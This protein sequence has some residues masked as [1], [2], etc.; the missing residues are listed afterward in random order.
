VRGSGIGID[1]KR[2][3]LFVLPK[4]SEFG[5]LEKH[6]LELLSRLQGPLLH[7]LVVCFDRDNISERLDPNLSPPIIVQCQQYPRSLWRWHRLIR[8][9]RPDIIVF[10]YSWIVAFP[11]QAPV[12]ALLAGVK[13]RF[14]IQ[15]LIPATPPP[16]VR[17]FS[18]A[19]L[20]R[21]LA[22]KR[23]RHLLRAG[24]SGHAL[25]VTICV[26]DTVRQALVNVYNFPPRK[27]ITVRNGVCTSKFTFSTRDEEAVRR[28]LGVAPKEFLL[29]CTARLAQAKGVDVLLQAVAKVTRQGTPCKCVILGDGPLKES[30]VQQSHSLGLSDKVFFEGFQ[31]DVRPYLRAGS[32]FILT[33]HLEGLPLSVLEA[34]ACGLPCIVTNVGGSAEAVTHQVTGLVIPPAS[35]D[36]AADAILY[37]ATH[38][39][40]RA[41]MAGKTRETVSRYFNIEDRMGE[42][43]RV[44][45]S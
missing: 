5:G 33:S 15:H 4:T 39:T 45:L 10:C 41:Q 29:V 13:R 30:L 27:T 1:R 2:R 6:L 32:A 23:A 14:S 37:L 17:G 25:N 9:A 21:R 22:G 20:V 35:V 16:P 44:I 28:T 12:A 19:N 8:K 26:S 24:I 40:E 38:P 43:I 18:P 42:L 3:I 11:W 7:T 36:A 31:K 34:M